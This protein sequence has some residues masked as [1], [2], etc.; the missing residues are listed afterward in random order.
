MK[1]GY[2]LFNNNPKGY[3]RTKGT[4]Y[5][6][7][8]KANKTLKLIKGKPL[9]YQKQVV[10]TLLYRAKHHPHPT[11]GMKDAEKI[12]SDWLKSKRQT[13]KNHKAK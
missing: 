1:V 11:E 13:R 2:R 8:A 5:K 9:T 4:G 12:F 6:N 3:P 7:A 10:I